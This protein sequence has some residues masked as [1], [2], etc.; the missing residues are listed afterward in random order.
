MEWNIKKWITVRK[1]KETLHVS[2]TFLL[3]T[4]LSRGIV[5]GTDACVLKDDG[6]STNVMTSEFVQNIDTSWMYTRQLLS[7]HIRVKTRTQN[8]SSSW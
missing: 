4:F 1:R 5:Y 7:L 3:A 8:L 6:C 2:W